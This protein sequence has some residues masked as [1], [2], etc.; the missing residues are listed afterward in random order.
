M[1]GDDPAAGGRKQGIA[2]PLLRILNQ[3]QDI[4]AAG[5]SILRLALTRIQRQANLSDSSPRV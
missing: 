2:I 1:A 3:G 4:A 5:K